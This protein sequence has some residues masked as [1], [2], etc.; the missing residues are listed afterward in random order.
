MLAL[1]L[2]TA[3]TGAATGLQL[4]VGAE[5]HVELERRGACEQHDPG[6]GGAPSETAS[7]PDDCDPCVDVALGANSTDALLTDRTSAAP[8]DVGIAGAVVGPPQLSTAA[9]VAQRNLAFPPSL[10]VGD[11]SLSGIRTIVLLI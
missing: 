8:K 7:V 3:G 10:D 2:V 9:R 5:G 1:L 6:T 4:C 11:A